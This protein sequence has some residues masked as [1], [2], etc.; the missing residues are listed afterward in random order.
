MWP[1]WPD[2]KDRF[3]RWEVR[4]DGWQVLFL[5]IDQHRSPDQLDRSLVLTNDRHRCDRWHVTRDK[6]HMTHDTWFVAHGMTWQVTEDIYIFFFVSLLLS[7]HVKGVT[8][9]NISNHCT[10][11]TCQQERKPKLEIAKKTFISTRQI[12]Y[13]I[14]YGNELVKTWKSHVSHNFPIYSGKVGFTSAE[15]GLL[16]DAQ[17]FCPIMWTEGARQGLEGGGTLGQQPKLWIYTQQIY[18]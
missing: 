7:A 1:V 11:Y 13:G 18:I 9:C 5:F 14:D 6:W 2:D 15:P 16:I 8:V 3:D 4:G 10:C 12:V 17:W